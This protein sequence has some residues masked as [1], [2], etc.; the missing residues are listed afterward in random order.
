MTGPLSATKL[1]VHRYRPP[2]GGCPIRQENPVPTS[3]TIVEAPPSPSTT[4][5]LVID[6][7]LQ[8]IA[9]D[10]R[11][12]EDR[13][14]PTDQPGPSLEQLR[15]SPLGH[16]LRRLALVAEGREHESHEQVRTAIEAVLQLLFWPAGADQYTVP[17]SFWETDLGHL[18]ARAKYQTFAASDLV[19]IGV[20][21]DR[22]GVTR[23]TVYRWMEDRSLDSVRDA[24]SGRTYIVRIGINALQDRLTDLQA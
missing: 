19:G 21:A 14:R 8:L 20:A 17:R 3:P 1:G 2:R 22:F 6:Q 23:P 16:D 7:A 13:L 18:L 15:A 5:Q 12:L 9:I 11:R 24:V 10:A 4:A